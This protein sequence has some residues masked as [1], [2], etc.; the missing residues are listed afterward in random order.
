MFSPY[1]HRMTPAAVVPMYTPQEAIEEAEYAINEL[2]MKVVMIVNHIKRPIAAY[3]K[4]AWDM[5]S[6][7]SY[8]DPLAL[9]SAYDYDPFWAK[10]VELKVAVT[11]HSGSM[12]WGGR[13]SVNNFSYSRAPRS[14]KWR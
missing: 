3:A 8:I 2:G 6:V 12:G 14:N 13:V 1:A 10:C 5:A 4:D 9:D 7:P 11:A